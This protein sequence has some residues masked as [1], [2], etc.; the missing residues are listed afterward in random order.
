MGSNGE[1]K[2][3]Q[4]RVEPIGSTDSNAETKTTPNGKPYTTF[5]IA[6]KTSYIKDGVRITR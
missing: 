4:N 1:T 6:T 2:M 3:Y 5:S